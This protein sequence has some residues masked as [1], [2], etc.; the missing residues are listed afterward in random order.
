MN[1]RTLSSDNQEEPIIKRLLFKAIKIIV[2]RIEQN[3][4][5]Y[6]SDRQTAKISALSTGNAEK[7][8]IFDW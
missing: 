1:H 3:K 4:A 6:D 5:K 8:S 7:T 2:N